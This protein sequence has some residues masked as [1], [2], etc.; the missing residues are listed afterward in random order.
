MVRNLAFTELQ[1]DP[2]LIPPPP[3]PTPAVAKKKSIARRVLAQAD[4]DTECNFCVFFFI[5]GVFTMGLLD[6]LAGQK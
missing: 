6:A 4:D 1:P 3:P 5:A 2:P